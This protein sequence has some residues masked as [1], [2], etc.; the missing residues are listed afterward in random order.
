VVGLVKGSYKGHRVDFAGY[1]V[2]CF[3]PH[4]FCGDF[5]KTLGCGASALALLTG[6]KPEEVSEHN[7]F[8]AHYSDTFM[9]RFL[10][11]RRFRIARLTLC[12]L[13]V[14]TSRIGVSHVIL[15]S[16][17]VLK[18]EATWSVVHNGCCYHNFDIFRPNSLTFLNKPLLS[19]YLVNSPAWKP[20]SA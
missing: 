10:R 17:L 19:A 5:R 12:N 11:S 3:T 7:K 16:Q 15:A 18:N 13:S 9:L 1:A 2:S 14:A 20:T 6:V 8:R 4:L